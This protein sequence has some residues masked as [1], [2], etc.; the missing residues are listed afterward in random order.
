ML[1]IVEYSLVPPEKVAM[2]YLDDLSSLVVQTASDSQID[3]SG[4]EKVKSLLILGVLTVT[5]LIS[6]TKAG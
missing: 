2:L 6:R 1:H 4:R 3:G 5:S